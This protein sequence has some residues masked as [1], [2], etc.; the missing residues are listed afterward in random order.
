MDRVIGR[1]PG[2]C[3]L[4]SEDILDCDAMLLAT[5]L[6]APDLTA[7]L[8]LEVDDQGRL[9]TTA[10]LQSISDPRVFAVGD[11]AVIAG[12]ARPCAGVFGVR[13][14]PILVRNLMALSQNSPLE[15][16][17]PQTRWLSIMDL[18]DGTG[19]ALWGRAWWLGTISLNWKRWLDL[20]FVRKIRAAEVKLRTRGLLRSVTS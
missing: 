8:G 12:A 11:C 17:R 7:S 10:T 6:V 5:G 18:G 4:A 9:V 20:G 19:L 15:A 16:Y 14:A 3:H 13:A 1:T 2:S